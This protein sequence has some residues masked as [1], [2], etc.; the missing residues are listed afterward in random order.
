M[1]TEQGD[2]GPIRVSFR[3]KGAVDVARFAEEFGGGGHA[4][5][6]GAKLKGRLPEVRDRVV[7]ALTA[8]C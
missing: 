7:A 2:D 5:A 4:R 6:A 1:V 8:V 3:S